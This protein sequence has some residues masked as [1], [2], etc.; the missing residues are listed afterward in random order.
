M[1]YGCSSSCCGCADG[2][3]GIS[4]PIITS[5][6]LPA[7]GKAKTLMLCVFQAFALHFTAEGGMLTSVG[8]PSRSPWPGLS[9]LWSRIAPSQGGPDWSYGERFPIAQLV[10]R[11]VGQVLLTCSMSVRPFE[12]SSSLQEQ[13][14]HTGICSLLMERTGRCL[15]AVQGGSV[16]P[17]TPLGLGRARVHAGYLSQPRV[18]HLGWCLL[19]CLGLTVTISCWGVQGLTV[20]RAF[21]CCS[22]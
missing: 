8:R 9:E 14:A 12:V 5:A 7:T 18:L 3:G 4:H 15:G 2:F 11:L 22:Q 6:L 20:R 10:N 13:K 1:G 19:W 17:A 16:G 21:F